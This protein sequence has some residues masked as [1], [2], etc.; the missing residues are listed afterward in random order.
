MKK[1]IIGVLSLLAL[2][3]GVASANDVPVY[4]SCGKTAKLDSTQY[5]SAEE[6]AAAAWA[7]DQALCKDKKN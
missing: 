2:S 3:F 5:E 7:I 4:T 1:K 6:M